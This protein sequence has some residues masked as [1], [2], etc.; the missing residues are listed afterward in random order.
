M[1]TLLKNINMHVPF[2]DKRKLHVSMNYIH[3]FCELATEKVLFEWH[4]LSQLTR[5]LV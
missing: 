2:L 4:P 3:R 5:I 1:P